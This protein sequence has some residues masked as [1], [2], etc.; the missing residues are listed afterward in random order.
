M[1][2][3]TDVIKLFENE[4]EIYSKLKKANVP[5]DNHESDL[6]ALVT[7]ESEKI[8][9]A[10]EFKSLVR[11]FKSPKDDKLW[12]EIPLA[13]QPFWDGKAMMNKQQK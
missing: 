9:A 12:F 5:L 7:P 3:A 4:E 11:K 10:Y 1:S 8:V 2:K 13:Y 6:Y